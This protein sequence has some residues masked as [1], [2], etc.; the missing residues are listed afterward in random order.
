MLVSPSL[1][2][3]LRPLP[4]LFAG[5]L[6]TAN[7]F[8]QPSAPIDYRPTREGILYTVSRDE[9][10]SSIAQRVTGRAANWRAISKANHIA[11][12]RRL[13]TGAHILIP[14]QLLPEIP[15]QASLH[16]VSGKVR[17]FGK[18]GES[19]ALRPGL[20]LDE[21]TLLV[22]GEDG[23]ATLLLEDG[24]RFT[25]YP[26]S[27]LGLR[28]LRASRTTNESRTRLFLEQG[29]IESHV[30]P[31]RSKKGRHY[32]VV[33]PIAVSGVRGTVFRTRVETGRALNEVM[34][35]R[36]AVGNA[37][38]GK[39]HVGRSGVRLV[40][41]GFGTIVAD[42]H[43]AAPV[44][45]LAP[46]KL[47]DGYA[48]QE[49]LPLQFNLRQ[50]KAHAFGV[51]VSTDAEG[52]GMVA[53]AT[54][55]A[56]SG[57]GVVK[58]ADLPNGNYYVHFHAIDA[59][60]LWGPAR[61][62]PFRVHARPFPPLL[63]QPEEKVQGSRVEEAVPVVLKWT[64]GEEGAA[65]RL[66]LATDSSFT[67][68]LVDR[69][70]TSGAVD[71]T[72]MLSPG[73]YVWRVATVVTREGMQ[74]QGPFGDLRRLQV[75]KAMAAPTIAADDKETRFSWSG[76]SGQRFDFQLSRDPTFAQLLVDRSVDQ[77]FAVVP[78]L[79]SG[80]YYVRVRSIDSDGFIGVFS[81][82]QRFDVPAFWQSSTGELLQSAGGPV[83]AGF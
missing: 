45:L 17:I 1:P 7:G 61:I 68:P 12:D 25:V 59:N 72:V 21:G 54:S 71:E 66:Q 47:A 43:V 18:D 11:D 57:I 39:K 77:P 51:E 8:A 83:S 78:S 4:L 48:L 14:A 16:A 82:I 56:K 35:G 31:T 37:D 64:R 67:A 50:D 42:G 10:L 34:E 60:G 55:E 13:P 19:L 20:S 2:P 52:N 32:E 26:D 76:D 38:T 44:A 27:R 24:T 29:R 15:A 33:S 58:L 5:I 81:P 3:C 70:V 49:R 75:L 53:A 30:T 22:T 63:L 73:N 36:V 6:S 74:D 9:T 79:N 23:F 62:V 69:L 80:T 40:D 46:P 65:Y 28:F 41:A